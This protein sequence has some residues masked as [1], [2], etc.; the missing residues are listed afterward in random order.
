MSAWRSHA[1]LSAPPVA[2]HHRRHNFSADARRRCS[3]PRHRGASAGRRAPRPPSSAPRRGALPM[4]RRPRP[5]RPPPALCH[6]LAGVSHARPTTAAASLTSL[7]VARPRLRGDLR[8]GP[9]LADVAHPAPVGS[10]SPPPHPRHRARRRIAAAP[11]W[12]PP[13]PEPKLE[14]PP[15]LGEAR[16]GQ[17]RSSPPTP[18]LSNPAPLLSVC[19]SRPPLAPLALSLRC[20]PDGG[21]AADLPT[22]CGRA[23]GVAVAHTRAPPV[24]AAT[25]PLGGPC[26]MAGFPS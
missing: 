12:H 10:P 8:L 1:A 2:P 20:R 11:A 18:T 4:L 17:G 21:R 19:P 14:S 23:P 3:W 24:G 13:L 22:R 6:P 15:L 25:H 5:P 9:A 26:P 16:S 7:G